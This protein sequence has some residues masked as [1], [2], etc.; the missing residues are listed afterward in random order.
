MHIEALW[1]WG[2]VGWEMACRLTL[3]YL[4]KTKGTERKREAE[5]QTDRET[6]RQTSK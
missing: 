2:G 4:A 5:R 1:G 3:K 6:E